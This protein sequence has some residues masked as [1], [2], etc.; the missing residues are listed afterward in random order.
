MSETIQDT[1]A[2]ILDINS[3][4]L[5]AFIEK[6]K[7]KPTLPDRK[8]VAVHWQKVLLPGDREFFFDTL[9]MTDEA[10]VKLFT[11]KEDVALRYHELWEKLRENGWYRIKEGDMFYWYCEFKHL[12][13]KKTDRQ[14][15]QGLREPSQAEIDGWEREIDEQEGWQA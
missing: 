12:I 14:Y 2:K 13:Q 1:F 15:P 11:A 5:K 9:K 8:D 3:N 7:G 4:E 10:R 6:W